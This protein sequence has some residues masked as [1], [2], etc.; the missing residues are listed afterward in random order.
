[1][2]IELIPDQAGLADGVLHHLARDQSRLAV[3]I[4]GE[5][6]AGDEDNPVDVFKQV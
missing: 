5:D 1:M 3:N 4:E 6:V 2:L